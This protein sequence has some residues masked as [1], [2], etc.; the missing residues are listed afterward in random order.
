MRFL[1]ELKLH[2]SALKMISL[3]SY[4]NADKYLISPTMNYKYKRPRVC[5]V[6]QG[7]QR[8][9]PNYNNIPELESFQILKITSF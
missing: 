1:S 7:E 8:R 3:S 4:P 2:I 9:K 5:A 6:I